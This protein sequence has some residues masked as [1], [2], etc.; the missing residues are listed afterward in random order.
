MRQKPQQLQLSGK[1]KVMLKVILPTIVG[2]VALMSVWSIT[3]ATY[4][5]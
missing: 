1:E 2:F 3:A 5:A 4:V